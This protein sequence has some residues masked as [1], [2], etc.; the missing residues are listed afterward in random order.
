MKKTTRIAASLAALGALCIGGVAV[1]APWHHGDAQ[2]GAPCPGMSALQGPRGGS[3]AAPGARA[4]EMRQAGWEAIGRILTLR[5]EQEGA[6][7]AYVD[8]RIALDAMPGVEFDK[9]AV[10]MQTRFERR[11]QVARVRADLLAKVVEARAEL[12]K[13][14][15]P[16]Q[17]YV[18]ESFELQHAGH[19][20]RGMGPYGAPMAGATGPGM[21][22]GGQ[23]PMG[24]P[25]LRK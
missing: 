15:G 9:P 21:T 20:M 3:D 7:K 19:G 10:D 11:A 24:G 2:C 14:F 1:A 16:E 13:A 4:A 18:L 22:L 5:P 6:W 8:A 12:L 23:C 17:K 25:G